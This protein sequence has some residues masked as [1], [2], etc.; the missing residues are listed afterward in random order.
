MGHVLLGKALHRLLNAQ[1]HIGIALEVD[2]A[3]ALGQFVEGIDIVI[4]SEG[5]LY[6]HVE[7]YVDAFVL[8]AFDP[9]VNLAQ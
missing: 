3:L 2:P 9:Q 6:V 4:G 8:E 5:A 7:P 1:V